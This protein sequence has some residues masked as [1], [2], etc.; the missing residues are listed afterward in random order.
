[1]SA[2]ASTRTPEPTASPP[3]GPSPTAVSSSTGPATAPP[4]A[5]ENL[6]PDLLGTY[7]DRGEA[8]VGWH[9]LPAGDAFCTD[10]VRTDQ[11]CLKI[12][13]LGGT[14][15]V[16]FGP[17]VVDGGELILVLLHDED[18]RCLHEEFRI[19]FDVQPAG[20][21]LRTSGCLAGAPR[22][23]LVAGEPH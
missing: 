5:G 17:L 3:A 8:S 21:M 9:L 12:T 18:G 11:S 22:D 20:I 15:P 19:P 1:M 14:F 7:F 16:D 13:R 6:G 23:L 4:L 10:R 2:P